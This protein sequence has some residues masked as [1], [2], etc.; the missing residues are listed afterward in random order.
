MHAKDGIPRATPCNFARAFSRARC[1]GK[2]LQ[3]GGPGAGCA[4]HNRPHPPVV[5]PAITRPALLPQRAPQRHDP[6]H[7]AA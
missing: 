2:A 7:H 4:S 1:K 3:F 6:I 5:P